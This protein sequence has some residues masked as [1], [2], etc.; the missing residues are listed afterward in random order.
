MLMKLSVNC[1]ASDANRVASFMKDTGLAQNTRIE[2]AIKSGDAMVLGD[3]TH[4]FDDS[5]EQGK[6]ME[7]LAQSGCILLLRN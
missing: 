4:Y 2:S 5:L 3:Y 7:S 6:A 1:L